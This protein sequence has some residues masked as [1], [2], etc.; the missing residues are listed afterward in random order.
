MLLLAA[1]SGLRQGEIF[2]LE[3]GHID[4]RNGT[5]RVQQQVVSPDRGEPYIGPP[6]THQSYRTVPVARSAMDALAAHLLAYPV[7]GVQ[8]ED[9]TD[10][11][12][13]KWRSA[14]LVFTSKRREAIRRAAWSKVW[15]NLEV[16]AGK[17][18]AK[19]HAEALQRWERRGRPE[20]DEPILLTVPDGSSMRDL[21]HFYAS[22]LIKHRES[23]KTVQKRLGHAKPSITLDTYTHLW[24]DEED[25]TRAAIESALGAVP[26]MCPLAA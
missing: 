7:A 23:V 22:V 10:P 20:G 26:P 11:N 5:V 17:A 15:E 16:V 9:R 2:G 4:F 21:R 12:R 6:K 8:M 14:Q 18:L 1:A 13:V 25:T 19:Q 3:V 24:P